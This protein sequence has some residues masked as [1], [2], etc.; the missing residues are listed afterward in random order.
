MF[1]RM[2]SIQIAFLVMLAL[3]VL[4]DFDAENVIGLIFL[5]LYAIWIVGVSTVTEYITEYI[6]KRGEK[7]KM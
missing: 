7:W 5:Q 6:E 1:M 2:V 4:F 3:A